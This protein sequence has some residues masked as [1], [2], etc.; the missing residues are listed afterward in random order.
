[1][2]DDKQKQ[3]RTGQTFARRTEIMTWLF[4]HH[5]S[6]GR[7]SMDDLADWC[8]RENGFPVTGANIKSILMNCGIPTRMATSELDKL[9]ITHSVLLAISKLRPVMR[10]HSVHQNANSPT[11]FRKATAEA[12]LLH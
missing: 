7:R 8:G 2:S 5:S 4:E 12:F 3:K 6:I 10:A 9:A 1:M 11:D